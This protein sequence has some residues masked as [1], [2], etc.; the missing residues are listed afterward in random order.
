[1]L[2]RFRC[3]DM[4]SGSRDQEFLLAVE[5][6]AGRD[7]QSL[8]DGGLDPNARIREKT[9]VE[10]LLAMYTRSPRFS[11]CLRTLLDA[12]AGLADPV[13]APV[14]LDDADA[15]A[16]A[17]RADPT[18]LSHRADIRSAFTPLTGGTPLHVAAE[19]GLAESARALLGAG[20]DVEAKADADRDDLNGHTP[21]FH[22]VNS[23][24]GQGLPVL[25]M[26][27]AAGARTDVL[28]KGATWGRGFEWETTFFDVTP[29]SYAQCGL[30]AQMHR[31]EEDVYAAIRI[32]LDASGRRIP[33][34][35]NVPNQYLRPRA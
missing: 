25:R 26:L 27:T 12:G 5:R 33:P 17:A 1:M 34:L 2:R 22:V 14:L 9:P 24:A 11:D 4:A 32:M 20:A 23:I 8:L 19:Y 6:H 7:I 28:L 30:S 35:E 18:F 29:I 13:L 16:R 31:R 3:P 10:W 21:I 15:V